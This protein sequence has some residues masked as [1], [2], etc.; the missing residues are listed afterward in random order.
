LQ[1]GL[2]DELHLAVAPAVL[3]EG[4][5]LFAG[6]DL[7]KLGYKCTERAPTDLAMHVVLTRGDRI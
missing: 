4:E 5:A 3:G 2:I 6:I 1:A 7:V